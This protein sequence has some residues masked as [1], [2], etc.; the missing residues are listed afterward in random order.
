MPGQGRRGDPFLGGELRE[1]QA[2]APLDEPE[3]RRLAGGDPEL[4]GL[5]PE[6]ARESEEDG[7]E[8][9]SHRFDAKSNLTNH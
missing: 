1:R 7:P 5:L 4:F 2:R 6:L 8:V 3:Q 9:R